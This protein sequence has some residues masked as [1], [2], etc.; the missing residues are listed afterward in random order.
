[1]IGIEG[2]NQRTKLRNPQRE[3]RAVDDDQRIRPPHQHRA[4]NRVHVADNSRQPAGDGGEPDDGKIV[5]RKQACQTRGGHLLTADAGETHRL[6]GALRQ[7]PHQRGA[8]PVSGF[9]GGDQENLQIAGRLVGCPGRRSGHRSGPGT[10]DMCEDRERRSDQAS[11]EVEIFLVAAEESGDRLGAALMQALRQRSDRAGAI[12]RR[13]RPGKWPPRVWTACFPID[14]FAII[15]FAAIPG[16]LPRIVRHMVR[17]FARCWRGG[18][19]RWSSSTARPSRCGLRASCIGSTARS[20][21]SITSRRRSG[22]GVPGGR[23]R[24]ARYI[25]HVLALLPFEPEVHRRLGGPPCSY[26]GHP[27]IEDVSKLRPNEAEARRR[28]ADPPVVLAMPGS[29]SARGRRGWP[30]S[31]ARRWRVLRNAS[32]RS[33][34]C[35]RPCRTCSRRSRRRPRRGRS[36]RASSSMRRRSSRPCAWRG[37]R[38][39]NPAPPRWNSRWPAFRWS[40]PIKS[41]R[42]KPR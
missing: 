38:W 33:R 4:N 7:R 11:G 20:R 8:K 32:G 24:C 14:D 15:G 18:R 28:I 2:A 19:M 25:D 12:F 37:R 31:S 16:R 41:R 5:D 40:R 35:C 9:L 29:R 21:S 23:A 13:R 3:G 22:P 6:N 42:S 10:P 39:R 34:W 30:A 27:L 17:R 1:M 26:V 36:S